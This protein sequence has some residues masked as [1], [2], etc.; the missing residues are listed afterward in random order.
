MGGRWGSAP[1]LL[2]R[3]RVAVALGASVLLIP[4]LPG[5]VLGAAQGRRWGVG[6]VG[7][8]GGLTIHACLT[9]QEAPR[10]SRAGPLAPWSA[11]TPALTPPACPCMRTRGA[12]LPSSPLPS[13]TSEDSDHVTL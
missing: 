8:D 5:A 6:A 7:P 4:S 12:S 10:H 9:R 1:C 3:E 11:L 13:P 2:E